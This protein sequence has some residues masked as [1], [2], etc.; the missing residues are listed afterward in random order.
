MAISPVSSSITASTPSVR[1][2]PQAD[3]VKQQERPQQAEK[4]E[5]VK[6]AAKPVTKEAVKEAA[7]TPKPRPVV[8]TQGQTTGRVISTSA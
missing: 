8:N 2:Q 5:P 4:P 3:Q 7:E 1:S 6:Q